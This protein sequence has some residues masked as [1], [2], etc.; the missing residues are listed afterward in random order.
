MPRNKKLDYEGKLAEPLHGDDY[1]RQAGLLEDPGEVARRRQEDFLKELNSRIDLLFLHFGIDRTDWTSL[2]ME[3]AIAH[4]P[5]FRWGKRTG[6]KKIWDSTAYT[7]LLAAVEGVKQEKGCNDSKACRIIL[8]SPD[9]AKE[10]WKKG[11][12]QTHRS[13][14][15][16]LSEAR[17]PQYNVMAKM[18]R[19][20]DDPGLDKV[21]RESLLRHFGMP[22]S[23]N[24]K[25]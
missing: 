25:S 5:G 12:G 13:L 18:F 1:L 22:S 14:M 8:K 17:N 7:E 20:I 3:L 15:T 23:Q 4:V 19:P 21:M 2:A 9:F 6:P 10:R 24:S 16:R 11:K